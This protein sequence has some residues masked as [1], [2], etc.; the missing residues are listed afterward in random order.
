MDTLYSLR[1]EC[2]LWNVLGNVLW[3]RATTDGTEPEPVRSP[4]FR[5]AVKGLKRLPVWQM[6]SVSLCYP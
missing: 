1:L 3:E 4:V 2:M 5:P 6:N